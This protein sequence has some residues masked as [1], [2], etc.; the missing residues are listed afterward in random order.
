MGCGGR[1]L[2][3]GQEGKQAGL[4][5]PERSYSECRSREACILQAVLLDL[6]Q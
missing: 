3:L 5:S 4:M 2:G 6:E 1:E